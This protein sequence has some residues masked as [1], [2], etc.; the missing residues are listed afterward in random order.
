MFGDPNTSFGST[1]FGQI[2]GLRSGVGAR[3]VQFGAKY[4]F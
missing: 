4:Y 3:N 2:T 1:G